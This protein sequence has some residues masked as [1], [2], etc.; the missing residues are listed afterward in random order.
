M[1][2][3]VDLLPTAPSC[4]SCGTPITGVN[5]IP[6]VDLGLTSKDVDAWRLLVAL[7]RKYNLVASRKNA[8][9]ILVTSGQAKQ[10]PWTDGRI[11]SVFIPAQAVWLGGD[12]SVQ[13]GVGGNAGLPIPANEGFVFGPEEGDS[14]SWL[15]ASA[16]SVDVRCLELLP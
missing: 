13:T 6:G 11:A 15:I 14:A 9:G 7:Q 10:I 1:S 3:G 2:S 8:F 12:A 16:V 4:Q 5:G